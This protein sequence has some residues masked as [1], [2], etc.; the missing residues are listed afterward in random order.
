MNSLQTFADSPIVHRLGWT[1]LHSAWQ[2]LAVATLL[3]ICLRATRRRGAR[4]AY[5]VC[6]GALLLTALLPAVTFWLLPDP[7]SAKA[8]PVA[9]SSMPS[10]TAAADSSQPTSEMPTLAFAPATPPVSKNLDRKSTRPGVAPPPGVPV[11]ERAIDKALCRE[12]ASND[13]HAPLAAAWWRDQ[14]AA[15]GRLIRERLSLGLPWAVLVWATGVIALSVWNVGGWFAVRRLKLQANGPVSAAIQQSSARIAQQLGLARW[16]R[17]LQSGLVDSP[18]VIGVFKPMILLPASLVTQI[19]ADQLESLLAHELAH[20]LRHDY[21]VN[22]L[23]TA[24]ETLL[25]YHPAVWWMSAQI[26]VERENCCDDLALQITADRSIYVKALASLAGARASA[27][28]PAATGGLLVARLRRILGIVDPAAAYPSRWLTGVATLAL[29][30]AAITFVALGSPSATAQVKAPQGEERKSQQSP[31]LRTSGH[32]QI[33]AL[34]EAAKPLPNALINVEMV[35][36]EGSRK[37]RDYQCDAQGRVTLDLSKSLESL[38]L[39]ASKPGW[40]RDH[41]AFWASSPK[42][43][44]VV[45]ESAQFQLLRLINIGGIVRDEQSRPVNGARVQYTDRATEVRSETLT[46]AKGRWQITNVRSG[47]HPGDHLTVTHPNYLATT[48]WVD[49]ASEQSLLT[50]AELRSQIAVIVMHA[51]VAVTGKVTD[52]TGEPIERAPVFWGSGSRHEV[53]EMCLTNKDGK[54]RFQAV[55]PGPLTVTVFAEGWMPEPRAIV[56]APRMPSTDF[57]LKPGKKLRMRIVD[58]AGKPVPGVAVILGLWRGFN[59]NPYL[60]ELKLPFQADTNGLFE[61]DW[62]PDDQLTFDL[63]KAGYADSVIQVRADGGERTVSINPLLRISGTV[64]DAKTGQ[65]IDAFNAIPVDYHRPDAAYVSRGN[66]QRCRA[67]R[68]SLAFGNIEVTGNFA[69][70]A[71]IEAA[72]YKTYRTPRYKVGD[73]EVALSV[74]LEPSEPYL[75]RVVGGDGRPVEGADVLVTS[76]SEPGSFRDLAELGKRVRSGLHF[77]TDRAG[78]F[79]M[80]SPIE[81]YFVQVV[82][83]QGYA[84]VERQT[85]QPPGQIQ[86]ANWAKLTGRVLQSGKAIPNCP[87]VIEPIAINASGVR[88]AFNNRRGTTQAD[89]SFVIERVPPVASTVYWNVT[90]PH[91]SARWLP[92]QLRPG[93]TRDV[94][95]GGAG[96]EVTGQL[97]AENQPPS[98]DYQFAINALVA[99]RPGIEPPAFLAGKGFNW[100]RGW[101]L[102]WLTT[103]EGRAYLSTLEHWYVTSEPNGHFRIS[104]IGPGEYDFAVHLFGKSIEEPLVPVA[105]RVVQLS[106]KP[107]QTQLDLGKLLIPPFKAAKVEGAAAQV[108]APKPSDSKRQASK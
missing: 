64:I 63:L 80:P 25:F 79:E 93:E 14:S 71:Q 89:G 61:W 40:L 13:A 86:I 9:A 5:G 16:V 10:E 45:P 46:D 51:G 33:Q 100:K 55:S 42:D 84:A 65:P 1:L 83:S 4:A 28:A 82:S 26:R 27:L 90:S 23:Q 32:M 43:Q 58:R 53:A 37:V 87:V 99:K 77:K 36:E 104:G 68:F 69:H 66:P 85:A 106:I 50:F 18:V 76:A 12:S 103:S 19:P 38:Q 88:L 94:L 62:A 96:I 35:T 2:G 107:G 73:A 67:G 29:F 98:F 3:M 31:R 49:A 54:F 52:P 91:A 34:D 44:A 41:K 47:A 15:L 7:P 97:V 48:S 70:A 108:S 39:F 30:G 17:L 20:V 57:Q 60:R 21:L 105:S 75:G 78:S 11:G 92:V 102:D 101:T 24:I 56:V 74:R 59:S 8:P 95:L 6:C 22:L 81:P 72:G